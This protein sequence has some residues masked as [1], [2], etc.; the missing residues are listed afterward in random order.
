MTAQQLGALR[1]LLA[2]YEQIW[3]IESFHHGDCV[4]ADAQAHITVRRVCI[5]AR[6]VGH[7][8]IKST[9]RA[10][11]ACDSLW[12]PKDYLARNRDIVDGVDRMI[13]APKGEVEE[14]RSGTWSTIRYARWLGRKLVILKPQGGV[15][16]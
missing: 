9:R 10:F 12:P 13:A 14:L 4:G 8:P 5:G 2:E 16:S 3:K 1:D 7:P 11:M 6:I 15:F